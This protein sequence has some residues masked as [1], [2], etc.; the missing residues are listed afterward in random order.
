MEEKNESIPFRWIKI[1]V[2]MRKNKRHQ[3]VSSS[4]CWMKNSLFGYYYFDL[5]LDTILG[6]FDYVNLNSYFIWEYKIRCILP[7]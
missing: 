2:C 7:C 3:N 6:Q 4:T 1:I 5:F